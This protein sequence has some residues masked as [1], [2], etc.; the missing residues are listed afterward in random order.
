[1]YSTLVSIYFLFISICQ[2]DV[3]TTGYSW[4]IKTSFASPNC[5][6][7]D[8]G[9][10]GLLMLQMKKCY[11]S[12]SASSTMTTCFNKTDSLGNTIVSRTILQWPSDDCGGN[13]SLNISTDIPVTC[14]GGVQFSCMVDPP[15]D[16]W[17]GVGI[18]SPQADEG[19]GQDCATV[20]GPQFVQT[21]PPYCNTDG[22]SLSWIMGCSGA[23]LN[24]DVFASID[25]N[26]STLITAREEKLPLDTCFDYVN[27]VGDGKDYR[28]YAA[29]SI[30][31]IPGTGLLEVPG[32]IKIGRVEDA[33]LSTGASIGIGLAAMCL[34]VG[35]CLLAYYLSFHYNFCVK[36]NAKAKKKANRIEMASRSKVKE[37]AAPQSEI[38]SWDELK[39]NFSA[40]DFCLS[41]FSCSCCYEEFE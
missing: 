15:Q 21:V 31:T 30:A 34:M 32:D 39:G 33:A 1:M 41:A 8:N 27:T 40:S 7:P 13:P 9:V 38:D 20:A 37:R 36:Q 29:C 12:S 11:Q 18:W 2:R 28:G 10:T 24:Y 6:N 25:C 4:Y 26:Q 14:S 5:A 3:F 17:P 16:E 23:T 19:K 35:T 22:T